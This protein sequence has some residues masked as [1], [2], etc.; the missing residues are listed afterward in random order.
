[1]T[2]QLASEAR[3]N[4]SAQAQVFATAAETGLPFDIVQRMVNRAER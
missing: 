4:Q 1:M 3:D 2:D